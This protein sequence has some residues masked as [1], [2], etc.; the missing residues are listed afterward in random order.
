M[1]RRSRGKQQAQEKAVDELEVKTVPEKARKDA[2]IAVLRQELEHN[3]QALESSVHVRKVKLQEAIEQSSADYDEIRTLLDSELTQLEQRR[4]DAEQRVQSL[5]QE[6]QA[7]REGWSKEIQRLQS[8]NDSETSKLSESVQQY[9]NE[10]R[11]LKPVETRKQ[12]LESEVEDAQ[13]KLSEAR[14]RQHGEHRE[15]ERDGLLRRDQQRRHMMDTL[16]QTRSSMLQLVSDQV[17]T[18]TRR[19]VWENEQLKGELSQ[20]SNQIR[21]QVLEND[22]CLDSESQKRREAAITHETESQL[23]KRYQTQQLKI[24]RLNKQ[25]QERDVQRRQEEEHLFSV[26]SAQE[27]A[28]SHLEE[29]QAELK[30]MLEHERWSKIDGGN[31]HH[32]N[33]CEESRRELQSSN[34]VS[35]VG[36]LVS[37]ATTSRN[38]YGDQIEEKHFESLRECVRAVRKQYE[39]LL[40]RHPNQMG[41]DAE[42]S[43]TN[44]REQQ[45]HDEAEEGEE[46]YL[47][48][49]ENNDGEH[50]TEHRATHGSTNLN[51][52]FA[53][54][55]E[56]LHLHHLPLHQRQQ[57]LLYLL[58]RL[59]STGLLGKR[60]ATAEKA[61]AQTEETEQLTMQAVKQLRGVDASVQVPDMETLSARWKK[62][63]DSF[64]EQE[65]HSVLAPVSAGSRTRLMKDKH[66]QPR[67]G[68]YARS[69]NVRYSS[70]CVAPASVRMHVGGHDFTFRE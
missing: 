10:L 3:A 4:A 51:S 49:T 22:R 25:L 32:K 17:G 29:R 37:S 63:K 67:P 42:A 54:V 39:H 12:K 47:E 66:L 62:G 30:R 16:Q 14:A 60:P 38:K 55:S 24:D 50:G 23:R 11:E 48:G 1:A 18:T 2:A 45:Q 21:Q 13:Q 57:A 59:H 20:T 8:M 34:N 40:Q 6:L 58:A 33:L 15:A 68:S 69:R 43:S 26:Q 41:K 56:R 36:C 5:E 7:T 19:T 52:S 9:D 46:E 28:R 64:G 53:D 70:A 65:Q 35:G 61:L 44:E 27:R 31:Q